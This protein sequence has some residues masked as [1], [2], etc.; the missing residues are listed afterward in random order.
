MEKLGPTLLA[1]IVIFGLA[2]IGLMIGWIITGKSKLKRGSCSSVPND[3]K[4][5]ECG[6]KASC[7]LCGKGPKD[8]EKCASKE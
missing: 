1:T 7:S 6:N 4:D 3:P 2:I 5:D 8:M